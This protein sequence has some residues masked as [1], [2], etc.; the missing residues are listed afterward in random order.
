MFENYNVTMFNRKGKLYLQF[1]VDGKVKQKSTRLKDTPENRKLVQKEVI[2]LLIIKLKNG[3]FSR[4]KPKAFDFYASIYLR[5]KESLKTYKE[6][7]NIITNQFYKT[8]GKNTIISEIKKAHIKEWVDNKLI[9]T[10]PRRVKK[11]LQ[12]LAAIFD[13]AIE[14][15]HIEKNP[16]KNI[17]LPK[18]TPIREMQ[19]FTPKEVQLLLD[20]TEGWFR[21]YLAVAFFT[22]MRPGEI[23]ALTIQDINLN[24]MYINVNKRIKKGE[25]NTPKTKSS[26]RKVPILTQ[27]LPYI[28]DQL[29]KAKEYKTF[30][31]F[32]NPSTKKYF[33]SSDKLHLKWKNLLKKVNIPYRVMYN[34][35]HTFAT[36]MIKQQVPIHLVSQ[37]LGHKTIYETLNTYTK[38]LPNE[39]LNINRNISITDNSTDTNS[40][41]PSLR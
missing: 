34:T 27:L 32:F 41:I 26:I 35:R 24:E 8:F 19:P 37:T 11:L 25:V 5:Q 1:V 38:F 28:E 16:A 17:K 31:L 21:N 6:L 30:A 9:T 2:P 3:E 10:S 18:H 23:L 40:K 7:Y 13:I 12:V 39:N 22:G 14:Y 36:L 20:N 15:E 4:Q 33:F 29:K